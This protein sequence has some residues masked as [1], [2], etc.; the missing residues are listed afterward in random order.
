MKK[1]KIKNLE[2]LTTNKN[3]LVKEVEKS[4]TLCLN[5]IIKP[6]HMNTHEKL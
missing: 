4:D 6:I 5:A 2:L 1:V 3:S